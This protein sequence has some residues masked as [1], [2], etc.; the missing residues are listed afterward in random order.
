MG[1]GFTSGSA[2]RS[3][4]SRLVTKYTDVWL[5]SGIWEGSCQDTGCVLGWKGLNLDVGWEG[6]QLSSRATSGPQPRL[7][8]TELALEAQMG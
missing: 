1:Q 7:R 8:L 2:V 4:N 6:L 5:L 3:L